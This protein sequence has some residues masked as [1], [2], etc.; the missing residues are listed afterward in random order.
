MKTLRSLL[1]ATLLLMSVSLTCADAPPPLSD[2]AKSIFDGKTLDGWE[3]PAPQLWS[4]QDGCLTGGDG[5]KIP[6]NDF[7]CTKASYSNFILH[8]KIKLTGDPKTGFINSGIQIRTRRNPTGHEVC[9]YQCDYGEPDWYAGIY[10]EGRRGKLLVKADMKTLHPALNLWGWNDYVIKAD[11]PHIQTWINGVQGVDYTEAEPAIASDGIIGIQVHGGGNTNVQVKDVFIEDLPATPGAPTWES[12]GG[13][14]G[15]RAKLKPAAKTAN[16][17][18]VLHTFKKLQLTDKFWSEGANFGDFNRDGKMD[19]VSGPYWYEGPDFTKRHEYYPATKTFTRKKDDGTEE[20]IPGFEGG[21]GEKNT[22]SDNF[23]AFV[24]DFNGDGWPDILIYGFPGND[25]SWFENPQGKE[26]PWKRHIIFDHVDNESPTFAD[27]DG[28]G[29]PEII[30]NSGGYFGYAKADWSDPAKPWTFHPI[31]PKGPW[32]KFT[33]G[34]GVGD[35]N[36]DGKTDLIEATGWWEQPASLEGDPVW[37]HH[38]YNFGGG[39]QFYVYDVNGDG[40][41][42]IIGSA[43]AHGYGLVWWEQTRNGDQYSFRKHLIMGKTP[44]E[45]R[46]GVHFSQL[47]ALALA[48]IDGDGLMDIVVGK[49][50]WAHGKGD[51]NNPTHGDPESNAS[52]VIYW[53]QLQRHG[54]D[55]D[56]IPHLI[57]DNSGVGT[58]VVVGDVNGDGLPDV[59]VGNKKGTFVHLHEKKSV[60]AAEWEKAQPK[61]NPDFVEGGAPPATAAAP[62]PA[63]K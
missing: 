27:I 13:V 23:F 36:G 22:Y 14:E 63:G 41:P 59:I 28:D 8:L 43:A 51:P 34:L 2:K 16:A 18:H 60:S 53:F 15:Q 44:E 5:N 11:G 52:A 57:D 30:C 46:Y 3:S 56:W 4:V 25:A 42:D 38:S 54:K 48:D 33:H 40:L 62:A 24:Y 49:R 50:F 9:G 32:A 7:L 35:V 58:Q 31:S 55:V 19:I 47:H 1:T 12:L 61:P 21:L 37:K 39:A 10:D 29:K 26:G 45:N 20:V 6:Y 17:D